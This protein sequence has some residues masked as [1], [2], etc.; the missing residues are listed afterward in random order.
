MRF[1]LSPPH[2]RARDR[3]PR[4]AVGGDAA[5]VSTGPFARL[6]SDVTM[7]I[8]ES[9][10][11]AEKLR[12]VTEVCRGWRSLRTDPRLWRS[13]AIDSKTFSA[14][15]A[16]AFFT[17]GGK[18]P[19]PSL[20]AVHELSVSGEKIIDGRPALLGRDCACPTPRLSQDVQDHHQGVLVR[21]ER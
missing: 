17:I 9:L 10:T 19:L 18:S 12:V 4:A 15:G 20:S 21:L 8:F 11:F 14:R 3:A 6:D 16:V 2:Q 5:L 1:L 7:L 13:V